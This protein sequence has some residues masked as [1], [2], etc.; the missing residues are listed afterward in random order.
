MML[1]NVPSPV[2]ERYTKENREPLIRKP[3]QNR[4]GIKCFP[5]TSRQP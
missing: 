2:C 1:H 3:E 4:L 5:I